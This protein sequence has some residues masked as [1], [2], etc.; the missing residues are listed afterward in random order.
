MNK[1]MESES[2]RYVHR[3]AIT[4]FNKKRLRVSK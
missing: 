2:P 3:M 1:T 4:Q